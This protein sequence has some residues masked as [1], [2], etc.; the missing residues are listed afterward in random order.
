[1]DAHYIAPPHS[2]ARPMWR[3]LKRIG[4]KPITMPPPLAARE[5]QARPG[6]P[7]LAP[8]ALAGEARICPGP[9]VYTRGEAMSVII[10][11]KTISSLEDCGIIA[12]SGESRTSIL[13]LKIILNRLGA[14]LRVEH[15]PHTSA[16]KLLA[17]APC[18]LLL[19]DEALKA[20]VA[21]KVVEDLGLLAKKVLD[22]NPVFAATMVH[23]EARC[24]GR[25][26]KY[27]PQPSP[28]DPAKT[29]ARTGIPIHE[30]ERYHKTIR[31]DYNPAE[32]AK[33][34]QV[35]GIKP[36]TRPGGAPG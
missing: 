21:Y 30:A 27:R 22:V 1:M 11:S 8:I 18:A 15:A 20:R 2:Y 31:L 13:Y 16:R 29:S 3:G 25:L 36:A 34:L 35:L 33:A 10:A 24:P 17:R 26:G 19:G 23:P 9:M 12:V 7:G 4:I 32:L 28:V 5:I 6:T 14:K